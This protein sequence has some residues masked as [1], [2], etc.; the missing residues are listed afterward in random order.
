MFIWYNECIEL[1]VFI[2]VLYE[3]G[4]ITIS[5]DYD[6][7]FVVWIIDHGLKYE[8]CVDITLELIFYF[9]DW[10][11]DEGIPKIFKEF[12]HFF[13]LRYV[14]EKHVRHADVMFFGEVFSEFSP[15]QFPVLSADRVIHVGIVDVG[16]VG[17]WHRWGLRRVREFR[18]V[19]ELRGV[20]RI[21][22]FR[23]MRFW[24]ISS[25]PKLGEVGRGNFLLDA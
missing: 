1:I 24:S 25:S 13:L 22:R 19:S 17:F 5:R 16:E 2:Q 9:S 6:S 12:I 11:E 10:F 15:V 18:G 14:S 23:G 21:R 20:R 3:T 4:D 7:L 8:F